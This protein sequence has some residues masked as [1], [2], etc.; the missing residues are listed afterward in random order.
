MTEPNFGAVFRNALLRLRVHQ[1]TLNMIGGRE[2]T[3]SGRAKTA[4]N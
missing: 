4:L 2:M 1:T 3:A